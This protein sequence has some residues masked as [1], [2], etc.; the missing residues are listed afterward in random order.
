M[1]DIDV[2]TA[3]AHQGSFPNVTPI[4]GLWKSAVVDLP[5]AI[6]IDTLKFTAQRMQSQVDY[7]ASVRHY[8]TV[9]EVVNVNK[10]FIRQ[11]VN[12][13]GAEAIRLVDDVRAALLSERLS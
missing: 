7:L 10:M 5:A 3:T 4:I 8:G 11:A 2:G 12:D 9:P 13:Y 1:T 6:A